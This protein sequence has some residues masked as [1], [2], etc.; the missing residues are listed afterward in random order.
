VAAKLWGATF[1]LPDG[2]IFDL[3]VFIFSLR[4][5]LD[6]VARLDCFSLFVEGS[7]GVKMVAGRE[8]LLLWSLL[9]YTHRVFGRS[10]MY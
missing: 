8:K 3:F 4:W 2:V 7:A 5:E 1:L 10:R 9:C 6:R